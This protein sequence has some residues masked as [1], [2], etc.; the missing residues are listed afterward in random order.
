M[1]VV[2]GLGN[3]GKEYAETRHNIGFLVVE[4]LARRWN[5]SFAKERRGSRTTRV[6]VGGEA[7]LLMQPQTYMNCSGDAVARLDADFRPTPSDLIAVH[8]ELDLPLG[9]VA[10]KRGGGTGGHR[11]LASLISWGG[12]DFVR[13]RVGIGRPP[14]GQDASAHVLR[15]FR[16]EE[17]PSVDESVRRAADAVESVLQD[18]LERAMNKFNS[19]P[20]VVTRTGE[21]S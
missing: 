11:G 2:V 3:P 15:A 4:E 12:P 17:R 16:P 1:R 19:R 10:V 7:V 9:R 21:S 5:V 8:D 13:V 20:A 18:G 6:H 14:A